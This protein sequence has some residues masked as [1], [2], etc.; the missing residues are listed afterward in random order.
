MS[1]Q[2]IIAER[3]D[4]LEKVRADQFEADEDRAAAE[5]EILLLEGAPVRIETLTGYRILNPGAVIEEVV[6]QPVIIDIIRQSPEDALESGLR[7]AQL[8]M[9]T[10][11]K[12]ADQHVLDFME[13]RRKEERADAAEYRAAMQ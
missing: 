1:A 11:Q 3:R 9:E 4:T 13:A 8:Y 10:V 2:T 6:E 7:L 5:L 12:I